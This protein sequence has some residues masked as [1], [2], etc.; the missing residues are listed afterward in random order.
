MTPA[1]FDTALAAGKLTSAVAG[2]S[3][4]TKEYGYGLIDASKSV[5]YALEK[6]QSGGAT[7]SYL[8]ADPSSLDFGASGTTQALNVRKFGNVA[9]RDLSPLVGTKWLK[10]AKSGSSASSET[11][12]LS[13]DRAGMVPGAYSVVVRII[14]TLGAAQDVVV[15]MRVV[16]STA[17]SS[18]AAPIYVL[19]YDVIAKKTVAQAEVDATTVTAI[20][21]SVKPLESTNPYL[22]I[23]GSD[24]DNDYFICDVGELCSA[25]PI[26]EKLSG[27]PSST[28]T[29]NVKLTV[30]FENRSVESVK[31]ADVG[32]I[33][34]G[35]LSNSELLV[36][37]A[38]TGAAQGLAISDESFD[39]TIWG[40]VDSSG[41]E[42]RIDYTAASDGQV[43][44]TGVLSGEIEERQSISGDLVF[45]DTAG[46]TDSESGVA[47]SFIDVYNNP[48]SLALV[49]GKW[50]DD[51]ERSYEI[52]SSGRLSFSDLRSGCKGSG[53]IRVIDPSFNM[54]DLRFTLSGCASQFSSFNGSL[55]TGL[56]VLDFDEDSIEPPMIF[57]GQNRV[58]SSVYPTILIAS[59][60]N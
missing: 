34:V 40:S 21:F 38:E 22:L 18:S 30:G 54:Y 50:G 5:A 8:S 43:S 56:A 24:A 9:V 60:V 44:G 52:D 1:D 26:D 58:G 42:V 57:I 2:A 17:T 41:S 59:P 16:G 51:Y 10:I 28:S 31:N 32:G 27:I 15:S 45:T 23:A 13:V 6:N 48:S 12:T 33:W 47:L 49:T 36:F 35:E 55:V 20:D 46:N 37:T 7:P 4:K 3:S 25:W 19:V 14:D 11:Y 39:A 53:Q 29:A